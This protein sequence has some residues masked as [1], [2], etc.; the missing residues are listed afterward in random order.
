MC[1]K[2]H[3]D[4]YGNMS[5]NEKN[6]A[7]AIHGLAHLQLR[8]NILTLLLF[9]HVPHRRICHKAGVLNFVA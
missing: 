9:V 4:L 5:R 7:N 8:V 1:L 3:R 6:D 2:R